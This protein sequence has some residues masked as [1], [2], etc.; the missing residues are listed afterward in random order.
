MWVVLALLLRRAR[1]RGRKLPLRGVV[2]T[3]VTLALGTQLLAAAARHEDRS[4]PPAA[5]PPAGARLHARVVRPVDGDTLLVSARRRRFY[6]RLLGIDTPETHRPGRP[7]ECGGRSAAALM[8]R[9]APMGA[10]LLLTTDPG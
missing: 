6:V 8:R 5:S 7:L 9:L 4:Q 1:V 10:R 2:F 3:V